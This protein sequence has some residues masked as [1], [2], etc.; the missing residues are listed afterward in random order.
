MRLGR[1]LRR[2]S[3]LFRALI[4]FERWLQ[5]IPFRVR[6]DREKIFVIGLNK[7]GTTSMAHILSEAGFLVAEQREFESLTARWLGGNLTRRSFERKLC[8]QIRCYQAFQDV[9]F[10]LP[11]LAPLLW[12]RYPEAKFILTKRS[13]GEEWASSLEGA[14]CRWFDNQAGG[15]S[16]AEL[17]EAHYRTKGFPALLLSQLGGQ[18]ERPINFKE[19]AHIHDDYLEFVTLLSSL[20]GKRSLLVV[21][22]KDADAL[23]RIESFI[24]RSSGLLMVPHLNPRA[25]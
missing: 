21:D 7:T 4:R 8:K 11:A 13:S 3:S 10:S 17:E 2:F 9:P 6:G 25:S 14:F 15:R 1:K 22:L 12:E 23:E 16:W 19:L 24:C 18:R 20:I 5:S